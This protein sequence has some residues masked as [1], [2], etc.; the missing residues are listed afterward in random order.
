MKFWD[1]SAIIPLIPIEPSSLDFVSLDQ[2]LNIA[3]QRE[4]FPIVRL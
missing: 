3:A 2:R 4:G 1:S